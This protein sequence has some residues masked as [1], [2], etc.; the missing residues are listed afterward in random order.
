[1]SL[2][3]SRGR[4]V[5]LTFLYTHCPDVC[6]LTAEH[7]NNVLAQLP[8]EDRRSIRILAV[9][10]DPKGDTPAAVHRFV[11]AHRL[12]PEFRYLVGSR[13]QLERVW[14]DYNV[15]ST[16]KGAKR[17]FHSAITALIDPSGH[18][19]LYYTP[20]T[21]RGELHDLKALARDL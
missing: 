17:L 13:P 9:S 14:I 19:R 12:R 4:W 18:V 8:P 15:V 5:F 11:N 7:L 20:A 2:S 10:V 3:D 16:L 1:M 6:P 21:E